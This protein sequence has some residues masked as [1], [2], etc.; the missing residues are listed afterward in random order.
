M[1]DSV[2]YARL[3][4]ELADRVAED[5]SILDRLRAD[6]RSLKHEVRPIYPRSATS[7][8]L[9][10]TDGG[11]NQLFFDPFFVQI[12]RVVDSSNNE[13]CLE[14]I[15][16]TTNITQLSARHLRE[17]TPL[18][19]LMDYLGVRDLREISPMIPGKANAD[20]LNTGWVQT[21]RELIEWAVLFRVTRTKDFGTDTLLV[22]DGLLR[23]R[24]FAGTLFSRY[25]QGLEEGIA[26]QA[27]Q[28][29]RL[30]LAGV[31]KHSKVLSR[32]RLAM[33]L[34][35]VLTTDYPAYVEIPRDLEV[36]S[37]LS[38]DYASGNDY[39]AVQGGVNR[40]VGGKLFFAKFGDHA[41]DPIW[42]IDIYVPQVDEAPAILGYLLAD[43][44]NGFP[45][46]LYPQCLQRAH[47]HAA[48]V[49]FDFDLLQD[50]IFAALRGVLVGEEKALD[51]F[52]LQ[53]ADPAQHRYE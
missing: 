40:S 52:R 46:P 28:G 53:D 19:E 16:P 20:G 31:A 15:T 2:S 38:P 34:E 51:R 14:V 30:Y 36:A 27:R 6:I 50:E 49:A 21:Y 44:L 45:V 35:G 12:V 22:Y 8:S 11:N 29:R 33:A 42:P 7:I 37:Y 41:G 23:S 13:Y 32:Y 18:G 24:V 10:G 1:R 39:V 9:V 3:Q 47:E 5:R 17:G 43:A 25:L 26:A 48:L 4:Q